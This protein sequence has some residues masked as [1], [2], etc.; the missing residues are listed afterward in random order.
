MSTNNDF[1]LLDFF[2]WT[3]GVSLDK[4]LFFFSS[5]AVKRSCFSSSVFPLSLILNG[6]IYRGNSKRGVLDP[7]SLILFL[8][9]RD[10]Y[11]KWKSQFSKAQAVTQTTIWAWKGFWIT[12][13]S[14]IKTEMVRV[15]WEWKKK[16]SRRNGTVKELWVFDPS[17]VSGISSYTIFV[18]KHWQ[19]SCD[20]QG[21]GVGWNEATTQLQEMNEFN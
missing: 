12:F 10:V 19:W 4:I 9:E 2:L 14:E 5:E 1:I 11:Y 18:A 7:A 16:N 13:W 3:G 8:H 15:V 6:I 21:M 17:L 20:C